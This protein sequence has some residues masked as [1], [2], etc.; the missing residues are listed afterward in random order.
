VTTVELAGATIALREWGTDGPAIVFWHALGPAGS[1]ATFGEVAPVLVARGFRVAAV[2]GPG[3]GSSPELP[4][5]GYELER[6]V[7]ILEA[8]VDRTAPDGDAVLVG[9]S[10]GGAL[11]V[12]AAARRPERTRALVLLDSGH[13]DYGGLDDVDPDRPLADWV[14]DAADRQWR[15]PSREA[16]ENDLR[17][18]LRRW[19]PEL[20]DG[21]VA[22]L[23]VD[24]REV[25][26]SSPEAR[27]AA[28][29]SLARSRQSDTWP[30]I[31]AA[32][33][34]VLLLLATDE[35]WGSQNREHIGRFTAAVPRATV[36]WLVETSHAIPADAGPGLG[37]EIADWL[38]RVAP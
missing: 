32:E 8:V 13:I 21:F 4:N 20:R 25:V 10:W 18:A 6:V 28:F 17:G 27:G 36:R 12:H 16:F 33:I 26:G 19:T 23:R 14:R 24:D 29:R 22:G 35:P 2:D 5:G 37:D 3:F 11:A 15:W 9:H 7:E 38:A 30:A 34:P 31:A 1:G